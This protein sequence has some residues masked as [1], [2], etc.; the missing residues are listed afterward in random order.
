[1][2]ENKKMLIILKEKEVEIDNLYDGKIY[3]YLAQCWKL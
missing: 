1:M 2:T 3:L